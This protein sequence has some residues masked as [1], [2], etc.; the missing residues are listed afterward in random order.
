MRFLPLLK[1]QSVRAHSKYRTI[2]FIIFSCF[3]IASSIDF[4]CLSNILQYLQTLETLSIYFYRFLLYCFFFSLILLSV[5]QWFATAKRPFNPRNDEKRK[6]IESNSSLNSSYS[7]ISSRI[8]ISVDFYFWP[9]FVCTLVSEYSRRTNSIHFLFDG[10]T[11]IKTHVK[12]LSSQTLFS[13]TYNSIFFS[14][15][16]L[17]WILVLLFSMLRSRAEWF[18]FRF[19]RLLCEIIKESDIDWS[20]RRKVRRANFIYGMTTECESDVNRT[21]IERESN[22]VANATPQF[23]LNITP[24]TKLAEYIWFAYGV[25]FLLC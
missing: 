1:L 6:K 9:M 8:L 4:V 15:S 18:R 10:K 23:Q 17:R 25:F 3:Y 22:A 21:W 2:F 11:C 13:I 20:V 19:L 5:V 12:Y 14:C 7:A 24:L 16:W